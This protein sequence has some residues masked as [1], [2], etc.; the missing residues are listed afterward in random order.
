MTYSV[1]FR[2]KAL[3]IKEQE[4]LSF[5]E[6]AERFGAG[7]AS[8]VRW[9][10]RLEPCRTRKRSAAKIG[11]EALRRDVEL[12]PDAHR[13]ERAAR[14]GASQQ[15]VC[16][17][18]KRLKISHKKTLPHPKAGEEARSAFRA[19]VGARREAGRPAV[20]LDESGFARD[21]P[22]RH[23]Y[24][25]AGER[26]AGRRDWHAGGRTNAVGALLGASL[27][28]VSLFQGPVNANVFHAWATQDLLPRLPARCAVVMDNAA[29]HKRADIRQAVEDA[30]HAL[31][32]LPA[33]S[34]DLN[35]IE[36]KWAQAKAARR[37]RGCSIEELFA[38]GSL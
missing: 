28:T 27:L 33:C 23:G 30:G 4:G 34:P 2:R 7:K 8:L 24:A 35:P 5:E 37:R 16:S 13:H 38:D 26:C 25:Q 6:L 3:A 19:R 21:M 1:D 17:A 32:F 12:Y 31:E 36:H 11:D 10:S 20:F 15:G 18:L 29:F 9:S 22:R 14:L